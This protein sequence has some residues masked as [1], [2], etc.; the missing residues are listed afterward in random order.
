MGRTQGYPVRL[1]AIVCLAMALAGCSTGPDPVLP[2]GNAAYDVLPEG[3]LEAPRRAEIRPG[4]VLDINVFREEELSLEKATVDADGNI[5]LP[6]LGSVDAV[7]LTAAEFAREL[8]RRFATRFLVDPSVS[9]SIVEAARRNVT[10]GGAV[11]KPGVYEMPGRISLVD[12]VSLAEGPTNIA[13]FDQVVVFRRVDGRRVGGI[14][15]LGAIQ[16][17]LAPDIEILA[18]DQVLVGT[19]GLKQAYRDI[20]QASPLFS[21]FQT[22]AIIA[23]DN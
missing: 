9:V 16:A 15:D 8:E 11:T 10:V 14:F 17:G 4:D 12:A 23:D 3:D 1:L 5:Q 7:G 18:G 19:D 2:A 20:L 6:L 13:K 21:V 22:F